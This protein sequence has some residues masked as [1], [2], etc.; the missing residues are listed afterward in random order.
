M[1]LAPWTVLLLIGVASAEVYFKET[2]EDGGESPTRS[3][4]QFP[5]GMAF[6]KNAENSAKSSG[7]RLTGLPVQLTLRSSPSIRRLSKEAN[8]FVAV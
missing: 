4:H 6:G 5:G 3:S 7:C 8:S 2:F 1:S